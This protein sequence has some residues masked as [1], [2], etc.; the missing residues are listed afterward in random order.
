MSHKTIIFILS[1]YS[2]FSKKKVTGPKSIIKWFEILN[3]KG[4]KIKLF[5]ENKNNKR[6]GIL[7]QNLDINYYESIIDLFLKIYKTS[8]TSVLI[9]DKR[10]MIQTIAI[11]TIL[12]KK[13][14]IRILGRNKRLNSKK[15]ISHVRLLKIITFILKPNIIIETLDGSQ[16]EDEKLFYAEKYLLRLNGVEKNININCIKDDKLFVTVGRNSPEKGLKN[17]IEKFK[18]IKD[19]DKSKLIVF[20]TNK[21]E[22]DTTYHDNSIT[23]EGFCDHDY[24]YK[25][26]NKAK[27]FITGNKLGLVGNAELEAIECGCVIIPAISDN[28][29]KIPKFLQDKY[30]ECQ[31]KEYKKRDVN[32]PCF[33]K[34]H[35]SD[36]EHVEKLFGEEITHII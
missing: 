2:Y 10:N 1:N 27:Y 21:D 20:G 19:D 17:V 28:Y 4:I 12:N 30:F 14:C 8:K 34:V 16:L 35:R 22:I 25:T 7:K 5:L 13:L 31:Q 23:F 6:V 24:I 26:L 11:A 29:E 18:N 9:C 36:I 32:L 15:I 33:A 3:E